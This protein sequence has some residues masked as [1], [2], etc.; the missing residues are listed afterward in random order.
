M[1][2]H[3]VLKEAQNQ[4]SIRLETTIEAY[5]VWLLSYYT[6]K[7]EI[8]GKVV[9]ISFLQAL[10]HQERQRAASLQSVGDQCLLYTGLFPRAPQRRS[11]K[12]NYF[13]SLGRAAY[14]GISNT[15]ELYSELALQFVPLMDVLQSIRP[16]PDL[17]PLEAYEQ[18][19]E[20]GSK[21]ALAILRSYTKGG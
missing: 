19:Q 16:T 15:S 21:R 6:A 20:L 8:I 12:L 17:L 11:L 9:A 4:C 1:L 14:M 2:W 18:W 13:V 10:Q 3:D 7:P 5:L